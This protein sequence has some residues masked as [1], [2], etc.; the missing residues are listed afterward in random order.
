MGGKYRTGRVIPTAKSKGALRPTALL[1]VLQGTGAPL[2][3][4]DAQDITT[5]P[6]P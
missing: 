3:L 5:S 1:V 4:P 2:N 6:L